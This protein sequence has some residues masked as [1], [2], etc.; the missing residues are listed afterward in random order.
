LWVAS[1][2]IRYETFIWINIACGAVTLFSNLN[3]VLYFAYWAQL[4]VDNWHQLT[5]AFWTIVFGWVNIHPPKSI[6]PI[7]SFTAFALL[8]TIGSS[9]TYEGSLKRDLSGWWG[10]IALL[11]IL[12]LIVAQD[13]ARYLE[14]VGSEFER[15]ARKPPQRLL[16]IYAGMLLITFTSI[17]SADGTVWNLRTTWR[18]SF[19]AVT[20]AVLFMGFTFVFRAA[21]PAMA[22]GYPF[23][24]V[25]LVL[26][27]PLHVIVTRFTFL[28]IGMLLLIALNLLSLYAPF[29]R[30]L[31]KLPA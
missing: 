10:F 16:A 31:L 4:L 11:S 9:K 17:I 18:R 29:I 25:I 7:L 6:I 27:A 13:F 2:T 28:G 1:R 8:T 3:G 12:L 24:A 22:L 20:L 23:L 5:T 14:A 15:I 21:N 26:I 30:D 19:L